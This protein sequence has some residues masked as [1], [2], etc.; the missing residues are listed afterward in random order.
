M[1]QAQLKQEVN[2]WRELTAPFPTAILFTVRC[3][4]NFTPDDYNLYGQVKNLWGPED[5]LS[6]RIVV[7]FTFGDRISK[8]Q[9]ANIVKTA[10]PALKK[11]LNEAQGRHVIFNN[12]VKVLHSSVPC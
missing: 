11:V 7:V 9:S 4:G 5:F 1:S 12:K 8:L 3:D 6:H 2:R 10:S